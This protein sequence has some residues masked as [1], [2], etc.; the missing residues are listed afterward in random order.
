M[1]LITVSLPALS[2]FCTE[3]P[4]EISVVARFPALCR[5][6]RIRPGPRDACAE[7]TTSH[8]RKPVV[9]SRVSAQDASRIIGDE[10]VAM[11]T[12]YGTAR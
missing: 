8:R 5:G 4:Y 11:P 12:S 3:S 9:A 2:T 1:L 10:E 6:R 7:R